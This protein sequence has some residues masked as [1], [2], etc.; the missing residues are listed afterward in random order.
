[1][2][3]REKM[4]EFIEKKSFKSDSMNDTKEGV[5]I[6]R[7]HQLLDEGSFVE[8]NGLVKS[9]GLTF[10][11]DREKVDGDGVITGY[12][13]IDGRLVFIASQD[14]EVY[15]GSMGQMHAD[16]ISGI[17]QMAIQ[18]N[19]PF[20]G[21]YDTGGARIEE[22][23]LALEGL[24]GVLSS[25]NEASSQIP[26]IAA[27]LGPCPGGSA[28]AAGLSHFR[29]MTE[30]AAGLYMN[31][32]MVTAAKEGT[33]ADPAE[34]GGAA[35]HAVKTGLASIVCPDE[36]ACMN[37]VKSLLGY[38][39]DCP[40]AI[41]EEE[42]EDDPNRAESRLDEIAA[43][44]DAGY[45]MTEVIDLVAD[46]NS[47]LEI[48]KNYAEGIL[49]AFA[50]IGGITVGVLANK[51]GR[52]DS[53]MAGK[54]TSFIKFCSTFGIPVVSFVDCEGFAIGLAY[55]HSDIIEKGTEFYRAMDSSRSPKIGILVGKSIG[56]AYLTLASKASGCDFVYAW[57][58]AE[59]S[60]VAPD[61]AANII[62]RRQIAD[63][64][65]PAGARLDFVSRY[66]NEIASA[67]VAASLGHVDEVILPSAT[68]P[69]IISS[70]QILLT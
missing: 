39:P 10:G 66:R 48:A 65:D 47:V 56:T 60:V 22:G 68:R 9:R 14:P 27:I 13:T 21:L 45:N 18:A 29:L 35:V 34:I 50:R 6:K 4:N 67:D 58:T 36:T 61:T 3:S 59:I 52:I 42:C 40:D 44:L 8:M 62:Y 12:G 37:S 51:A 5:C 11:F 70:L 30:T 43:S 23:V 15:A 57:P 64:E 49:T 38:L 46:K 7:I 26:T 63:S 1:M 32:P 24:A 28:F 31:G 25:L 55:E 69:R 2:G 20:V 17:I 16:K 53:K 33:K 19:A 41:L 54:A